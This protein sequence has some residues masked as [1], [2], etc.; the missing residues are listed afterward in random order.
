MTKTLL[1]VIASPPERDRTPV[2]RGLAKPPELDEGELQVDPTGGDRK[3]GLIRGASLIARGE[4]LG[5]RSW[6]DAETLNQVS[7]FGNLSS[8][9]IKVRFTHPSLSGDGL[10]T[11]LGRAKNLRVAEEKVVGDIHFSPTSR[12][13]PDGD[14]GKYVMQLAADDPGSFGMSIV[15]EHDRK[16]EREFA[17]DHQQVDGDGDSRFVSPDEDNEK[18]Y[19]HVRLSALFAVDFVD[20]PAANPEGLFHAG[21]SKPIL[22]QAEEIAAYALGLSEESPGETGGV[23]ATRVRD[24]LNRFLASRG[25]TIEL[26]EKDSEM[27]K[28]VTKT[29]PEETPESKPSET[30]A[31]KPELSAELETPAAETAELNTDG[32]KAAGAAEER[33][34][35]KQIR[36]LCQMS[37]CADK[38]E[39]FI[40]AEFSVEET[41]E[42]LS[43]LMEKQN[44]ALAADAKDDTP[45]E[46]DDS[47]REQGY[48]QEYQAGKKIHQQLGI[49]EAEYVEQRLIEDGHKEEPQIYPGLHEP[50]QKKQ[51]A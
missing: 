43:K 3:M 39:T 38:A 49:S 44:K 25:L 37:G 9:G 17:N 34:R 33:K 18:N 16:S 20:E 42:S 19:R 22:D 40:D 7:R 24:F 13:T 5:H 15:F 27:S 31:A 46:P 10:G 2:C 36:A 26:T 8:K 48:R 1:E 28:D 47:A 14:L 12:E 21:P 41:R 23:S 29:N 45:G 35:Q 51:P 4:A 50:E 30:P 11:F 6:I 32:I